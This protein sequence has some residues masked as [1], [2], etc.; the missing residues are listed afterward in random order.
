MGDQMKILKDK[1]KLH[2]RHE[3]GGRVDPDPFA[4]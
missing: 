2:E 3:K 4:T 1:I